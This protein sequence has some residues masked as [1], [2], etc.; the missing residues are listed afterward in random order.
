M[1][2]VIA[3]AGIAAADGSGG[4]GTGGGTVIPSPT[5]AWTS[6][7]G[8]D[9]G[10]SNDQTISGI[11]APMS[12]AATITGAGVLFVTQ[13][14]APFLYT[15]AFTAHNA[16]VISWGVST[17]GT[18]RVAGT[19]TVLNNSDGGATLCTIAYHLV[20]SGGA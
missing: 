15:G 3:A 12:I 9:D 1:T 7:A 14:G 18:S 16:D 17:P 11:S 5:P 4:G 13:N 8:V 2:G 6:I 20:S 10:Y 19:I